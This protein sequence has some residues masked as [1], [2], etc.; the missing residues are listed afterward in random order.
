M[1]K[2]ISIISLIMALLLVACTSAQ[3]S[4]VSADADITV[5]RSPT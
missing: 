2:R 4:A 5:F 3:D 1:V